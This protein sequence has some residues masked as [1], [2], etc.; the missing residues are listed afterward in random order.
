MKEDTLLKALRNSEGCSEDGRLQ[1][2]TKLLTQIPQPASAADVCVSREFYNSLWATRRALVATAVAAVRALVEFDSRLGRFYTSPCPPDS[3]S[4]GLGAAV[5]AAASQVRYASDWEALA[6]LCRERGIGLTDS[7]LVDIVAR[8]APEAP[9]P[10][11]QG[12][13][14]A[15]WDTGRKRFPE[16]NP[17]K[18]RY[19]KYLRHFHVAEAALPW[20]PGEVC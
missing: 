15:W 13:G 7:Q 16:W 6:M 1:E 19:D 20:L 14:S 3:R 8:E 9:Q 5:R 10:T 4:C 2:V 12:L 11:R 18:I 17:H